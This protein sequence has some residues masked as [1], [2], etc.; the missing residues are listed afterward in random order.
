MD[1][2]LE[3]MLASIKGK[4]QAK[5]QELLA[6]YRNRESWTIPA[7]L[8]KRST[9][10][11]PMSNSSNQ[12]VCK[13]IML[14]LTQT[15]RAAKQAIHRQVQACCLQ[16]Q[17]WMPTTFNTH[18]QRRSPLHHH[19]RIRCPHSRRHGSWRSYRPSASCSWR[20]QPA[21]RSEKAQLVLSLHLQAT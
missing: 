9:A 12:K 19:N 4:T 6:E 10:A 2:I 1:R 15:K 7:E 5:S 21:I 14:Q 13:D 18:L 8:R 3:H 16:R 17:Q 11:S 20:K